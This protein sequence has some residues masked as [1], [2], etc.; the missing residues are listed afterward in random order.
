[1]TEKAVTVFSKPISKEVSQEIYEAS[2]TGLERTKFRALYLL[3]LAILLSAIYP[4]KII[5]AWYL[6]MLVLELVNH[7]LQ[8]NIVRLQTANRTISPARIYQYFILSWAES[9]GMAVFAIALPVHEIQMLHFLPYLII[10]CTSIYIATSTF[11]NAPLMIGH[12]ALYNLA[13]MF[14]A[15]RDV[16]LSYPDTTPT[17]WVQFILTII[18]VLFLTDNYMFFH[19]IDIDRRKKSV[20]LDRARK[21]AEKLTRQKGELIS[22]IGHELRTPLT[23][24]LGFSQ[25]L[26]RS[27]LTKKQMEYV[28]LIESSGQGL[29]HLL[30][31][32]LDSETLELGLLH[33]NPVA[34]DVAALLNR[35]LKTFEAAADNKGIYLKLNIAQ[36][37]P[38]EIVIDEI[39]LGQCISNLLS[40]AMNH[41]KTGGITLT[42]KYAGNQNPNLIITIQDT[43][44]GIPEHETDTIFEKFSKGDNKT[45]TGLG[46]WLVQAIANAMNGRLT[47]VESSDNGSMFILEFDVDAQGLAGARTLKNLVGKRILYI[48]D[49]ETNFMLI[50]VLLEEQG[51]ILSEAKTGQAA[52]RLLDSTKYDAVLCDLHLPDC[53]GNDLPGKIRALNKNAHIPIIAL[54]AQPENAKNPRLATGFAAVLAKPVDQPLL[55]STLKQVLAKPD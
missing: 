33:L 53:D 24:I 50:R 35:T 43:G 22:A 45:G 18:V 52:L 21:K 30:S 55:V 47:L 16:F 20:K 10:V 44:S 13:L 48:E 9:A 42:A 26:K 14:I 27:K 40:N 5:A 38:D 25:V 1:M 32:I 4:F 46:L 31:N 29:Q 3:G 37:F 2:I 28:G 8:R 51:V 39:R 12:L 49:T 6:F 7:W 36:N 23:G 15:T 19:R 41:T 11:Q 17:L 54:T 34:T